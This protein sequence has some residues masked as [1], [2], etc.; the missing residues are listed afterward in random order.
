MNCLY[1]NGDTEGFASHLPKFGKGNGNA[2]VIKSVY[3]SKLIVSLPYG[4]K[5][6]YQIQYC[7][8]CGEKLNNYRKL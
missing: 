3:G 7:P 5:L 1:C 2:Y 4:K 6:N 8:M